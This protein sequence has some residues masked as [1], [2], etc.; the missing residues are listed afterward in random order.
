MVIPVYVLILIL[1]GLISGGYRV[2]F[3]LKKVIKGIVAGAIIILVVYALLPHQFRFSRA[4]I[5]LGVGLSAMISLSSKYIL[6][7]SGVSEF[8][9]DVEQKKHVALVGSMDECKRIKNILQLSGVETSYIVNVFH[10]E[11][12][13]SEFFVGNLSQLDEIIAV[14]KIDEIIFSAK[15]V[16]SFHIIKN[17]TDHS[18]TKMNFKIASPD[19]ES[20]IGSNSSNTSGDLYVIKVDPKTGKGLKTHF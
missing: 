6:S 13:P 20:V 17:M 12:I 10:D 16:S 9:L 3:N 18:Q 2:P 4:V 15:D 11:I 8:S 14:H 7:L 1:S 5:L 19:S